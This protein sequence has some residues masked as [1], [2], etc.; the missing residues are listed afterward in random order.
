MG[1]GITVRFE[2]L[3][4]N[5]KPVPYFADYKT[6]LGFRGGKRGGQKNPAPLPPTPSQVGYI[7]TMRRTPISSQIWGSASYR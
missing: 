2:S 5:P 4:Y 7:R 1:F 3:V 6:H